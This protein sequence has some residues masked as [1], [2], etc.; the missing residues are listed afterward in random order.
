MPACACFCVNPLVPFDASPVQGRSPLDKLAHG[1]LPMVLAQ[2][3][4]AII[5]SRMEV[6]MDRYRAQYP[7]ADI[8]CSNPIAR[9]P[10]FSASFQLCAPQ[11]CARPRPETV[12]PLCA[13]GGAGPICAAASA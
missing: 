9:M 2:A 4:R 10:M 3:F 8:L 13:P 11:V 6:G 1:G 5:H 7:D 12:K